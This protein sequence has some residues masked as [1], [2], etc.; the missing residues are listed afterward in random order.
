LLLSHVAVAAL[1][2]VLLLALTGAGGAVAFG[3]V[4][5]RWALG[6]EGMIGGS[7][8]QAPAA[9][10]LGALVLA[11]VALTPRWAPAVG[12]SLL[13]AGLVMGQ[14]GALLD[15]PQPVLNLSPFTHVPAVPAEA[16]DWRPL[17]ALLAVALA[18]GA[19]AVAAFRRRDLATGA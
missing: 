14:L 4:T 19:G 1:G 13:A 6:V 7:L 3:A 8:A 16:V 15:L 11:A 17:A 10:L 12:W 18:V 2:T 9:L 5:G